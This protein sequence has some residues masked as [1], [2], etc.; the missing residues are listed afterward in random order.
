MTAP[1]RAPS[2][3]LAL[4]LLAGCVLETPQPLIP[5]DRGEAVLGQGLVA[6][7]LMEL[8]PDSPGG[9]RPFV[10]PSHRR[11]I[12]LA[13]GRHYLLTGLGSERGQDLPVVLAFVPLDA[14]GQTYLMEVA[15]APDPHDRGGPTETA[16][17]Y[18]TRDDAAWTIRF[19]VCGT[20]LDDPQFAGLVQPGTNG[21][22]P[23]CH[24]VPDPRWSMGADPLALFVRLEPAASPPLLR[25]VPAAAP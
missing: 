14:A 15:P 13:E 16:Y 25:L 7:E 10:A 5:F 4:T 23:P 18:L 11:P 22:Y 2:A 8:N 6:F 20:P 24:P 3:M 1:I 17:G 9:W 19:L 21:D 12:L